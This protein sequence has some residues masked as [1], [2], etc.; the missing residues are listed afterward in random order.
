MRWELKLLNKY[1]HIYPLQE[2][3]LM[4]F[5]WLMPTNPDFS[6]SVSMMSTI[7]MLI[8]LERNPTWALRLN[9]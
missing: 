4:M 2:V 1:M 5:V 9:I 6:L 8:I 7:M 3:N